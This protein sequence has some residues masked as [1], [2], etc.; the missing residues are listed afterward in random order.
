VQTQKLAE[1]FE[2]LKSSLAQPCPTTPVE[3]FVEPSLG[4]KMAPKLL[5]S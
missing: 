2:G 4:F 1:F 5:H 3:G